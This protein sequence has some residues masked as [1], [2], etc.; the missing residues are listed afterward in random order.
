M[1]NYLDP[2]AF[3]V[4]VFANSPD[5]SKSHSLK[6][7]RSLRDKVTDSLEDQNIFIE[8]TRNAVLGAVECFPDIFKQQDAEIFWQ[9]KDKE[10]AKEGFNNGFSE[11]F[12]KRL[13]EAIKEALELHATQ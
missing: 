1:C 5:N 7:L 4:Y 2:A 9:G 13:D 10:L 8:W 11:D 6:T 3:M 12:E